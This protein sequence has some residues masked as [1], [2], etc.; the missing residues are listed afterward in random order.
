MNLS[1]DTY[2]L[3]SGESWV[4][5]EYQWWSE[6]NP[7]RDV[8]HDL[9]ITYD[10]A[11]IVQALAQELA[12]WLAETLADAGLD[13]VLVRLVD[14]WSPKYY[15]FESDGFEVEVTCDPAQLREIS[16]GFNVDAWA[17]AYYGSVD[18]FRSFVPTR[19][20]DA[21]WRADY[22]GQFRIESVLAALGD[23]VEDSWKYR[24]WESEGEIYMEHTVVKL[25]DPAV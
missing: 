11:A 17:E 2:H 3:F 9:D 1:P 6:K 12:D 13:S 19:M 18:G 14:T 20:H 24:L 22:D 4:E 10:H 15:N 7:D 23:E 8:S 16:E 21:D 25:L 5:S